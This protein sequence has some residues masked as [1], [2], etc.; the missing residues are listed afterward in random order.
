MD[1]AR[2]HRHLLRLPSRAGAP[3]LNPSQ[4][5]PSVSP[6]CLLQL[7]SMMGNR[8]STRTGTG[9]AEARLVPSVGQAEGIG[10]LER[11]GA[12]TEVGLF[13]ASANGTLKL[14]RHG[15][16]A[17]PAV[18]DAGADAAPTL[19]CSC[20]AEG[21]AWLWMTEVAASV[22]TICTLTRQSH[23][24]GAFPARQ[25]AMTCGP[26]GRDPNPAPKPRGS[27]G[28]SRRLRACVFVCKTRAGT[29]SLSPDT[30]G[31]TSP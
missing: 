20:R 15:G 5:G 8:D 2:G 11:R 21:Q 30:Q 23:Q 31:V 27:P 12:R 26:S 22:A 1:K 7:R 6:E 19:S 3:S 14:S 18:Q 25:Q 29:A 9:S 28:K 24:G 4:F 16:R 10:G 13:H 17:G